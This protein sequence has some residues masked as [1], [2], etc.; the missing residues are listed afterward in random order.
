MERGKRAINKHRGT[1]LRRELTAEGALA[2]ARHAHELAH[3]AGVALGGAVV[4]LRLARLRVRGGE[5]AN[6]KA[7]GATESA[8]ADAAI[9]QDTTQ[10]RKPQQMAGSDDNR[11]QDGN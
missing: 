7:R 4:R 3:G 1:G 9:P 10:H 8:P 5:K 2:L 11:E 6:R